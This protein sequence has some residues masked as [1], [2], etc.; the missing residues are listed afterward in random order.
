MVGL[1][2]YT[3]GELPENHQSS[4]SRVLQTLAK[5]ARSSYRNAYTAKR[6]CHRGEQ[7]TSLAYRASFYSAIALSSLART[8]TPATYPSNS[9]CRKL[10]PLPLILIF[11][12]SFMQ[13]F[14]YFWG[15]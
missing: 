10:K 7:R 11:L 9:T 5:L 2:V 15:I 1:F 3:C 14:F 6:A 4:C 12:K 8:T 13:H